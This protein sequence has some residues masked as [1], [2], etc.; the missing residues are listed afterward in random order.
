LR[1]V[2]DAFLLVGVVGKTNRQIAQALFGA[3]RTAEIQLTSTY[4]KLGIKSRPELQAALNLPRRN[5]ER[6]AVR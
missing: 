5:T 2:T 4:A 3:Q 1:A 6:P